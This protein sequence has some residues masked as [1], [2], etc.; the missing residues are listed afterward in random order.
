MW[1]RRRKESL[2]KSQRESNCRMKKEDTPF[3][4]TFLFKGILTYMLTFNINRATS[5][6]QA[7]L[8]CYAAL[9]GQH[10]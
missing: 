8:E 3:A 4:V 1:E 6:K 2:K 5:N 10:E 7:N 9:N